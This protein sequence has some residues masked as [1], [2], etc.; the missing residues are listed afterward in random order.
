MAS[1]DLVIGF[2]IQFSFIDV[3]LQI[4]LLAFS[5]SQLGVSVNDIYP[6]VLEEKIQD[7]YAGGP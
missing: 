5:N 1:I 7:G 3:S 2:H 4:K 6:P